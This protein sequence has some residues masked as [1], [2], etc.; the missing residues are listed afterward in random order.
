MVEKYLCDFIKDSK[1][2]EELNISDNKLQPR[3]FTK[4]F[5][6]LSDNSTIKYLNLSWNNLFD[7]GKQERSVVKQKV[8]QE[9][10]TGLD[11]SLENTIQY[12]TE[13]ELYQSVELMSEEA[14]ASL[15]NLCLFMTRNKN[16][17]HIDL[18][19]TGLTER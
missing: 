5:L 18:S 6:M 4:F 13:K 3:S 12:E 17:I 10:A 9:K 1:T 11:D 19:N 8:R 15:E 2:L 14:R 7:D 16:L